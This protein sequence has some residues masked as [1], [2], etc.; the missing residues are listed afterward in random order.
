MDTPK[1]VGHLCMDGIRVGL[2][3]S[4]Y[5]GTGQTCCLKAKFKDKTPWATFLMRTMT[6]V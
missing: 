5:R 4:V 6:L 2:P 1:E 3:I